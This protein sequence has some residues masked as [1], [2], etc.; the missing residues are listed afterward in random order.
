ML[1]LCFPYINQYKLNEYQRDEDFFQNIFINA[2]HKIGKLLTIILPWNN[3]LILTR[4][5]CIWEV[6][7]ASL[8][9]E[10]KTEIILPPEEILKFQ[11]DFV[12]MGNKTQFYNSLDSINIKN[13][14]AYK[15]SDTIKILKAC[16][17][18]LVLF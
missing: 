2:I 12:K 16:Q 4:S 1:L 15:E 6:Y 3:P 5:W 7:S 9:K 18:Y 8:S 13:A 10:V 17:V 11:N 14:K